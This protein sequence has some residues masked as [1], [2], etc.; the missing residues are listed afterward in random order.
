MSDEI[1]FI[2][3]ICNKSVESDADDDELLDVVMDP[4]KWQAYHSSCLEKEKKE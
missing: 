2:C 4:D 1:N 3:P